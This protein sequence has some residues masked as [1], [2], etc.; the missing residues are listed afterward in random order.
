MKPWKRIEPTI[1]S[2]IGYRTIVTKTFAMPDGRV[3]HFQTVDAESTH[4]AGV[5]AFTKDT[6]VIVARQF[7]AGPEKMMD[8]IPGGGAEPGEDFMAAAVRELEEE[9][10]Y[11]PGKIEPLGIIYKDAY[12]NATWHYFLATDCRLT[13]SGQNP[14]DGEHVE[15]RLISID[16]FIN[17]A[18]SGRMTDTEAVFLAYEKLLKLKGET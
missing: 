4:G 9:T 3:A 8:E 16:E 11:Q 2:K 14:D 5:I 15:T 1:V 12:F 18:R 7:R 6:Q 10:G 13:A 17:N